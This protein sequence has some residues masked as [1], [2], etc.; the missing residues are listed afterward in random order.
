M[1]HTFCATSF[2]ILV[3]GILVLCPSEADAAPIHKLYSRESMLDIGRQ[4]HNRMWGSDKDDSYRE[5]SMSREN[6]EDLSGIRSLSRNAAA[7]GD[8][9][10][11]PHGKGTGWRFDLR[12]TVEADRSLL[13]NA[14][15]NTR[16]LNK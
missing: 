11:S 14:G 13:N 6:S 12:Q 7:S 2:I 8:S 16:L 10:P 3:C 5:G 1:D 9:Y 15:Q 4:G